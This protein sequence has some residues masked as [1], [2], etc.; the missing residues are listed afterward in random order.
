MDDE[1]LVL[2]ANDAFYSAFVRRDMGAMEALWA[3]SVEAT[4][5]HP[6]WNVL[7]GRETVLESWEAMIANPEQPRIVTGGARA[8]LLGDVAVV[9]CREFVAGN[10]LAATNVYVREAGRWRLAHHQ[11]GFVVRTGG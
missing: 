7:R 11:S 1:Q 6:G 4:C 9:T 8:V 3:G 10:A 2:A 5:I